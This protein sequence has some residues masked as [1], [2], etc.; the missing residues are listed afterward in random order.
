MGRQL[1]DTDDN[2]ADDD[3]TDGDITSDIEPVCDQCVCLGYEIIF[4]HLLS[5]R[6]KTTYVSMSR[7]V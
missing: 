7:D 3:A 1:L 5:N 6:R 2:T 4:M